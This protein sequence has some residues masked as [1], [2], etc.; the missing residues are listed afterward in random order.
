MKVKTL[1]DAMAYMVDEIELYNNAWNWIPLGRMDPEAFAKEYADSKVRKFWI[2]NT[3]SDRT[4]L[5]I[6]LK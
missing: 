5:E 1:L 4:I 3:Y 2:Y 6:V